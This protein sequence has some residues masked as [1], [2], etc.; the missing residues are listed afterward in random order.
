MLN[1]FIKVLRVVVIMAVV[2]FLDYLTLKVNIGCGFIGFG[3]TTRFEAFYC[4]VGMPVTLL[5]AIIGTI[6]S[7]IYIFSHKRTHVTILVCV[8]LPIIAIRLFLSWGDVD[9]FIR[10]EIPYYFS[11]YASFI[12]DPRTYKISKADCENYDPIKSTKEFDI[13]YCFNRFHIVINSNNY[14]FCDKYQDFSSEAVTNCAFRTAISINDINFCDNSFSNK[15]YFFS[16]TLKEDFIKACTKAFNDKNLL[17][18]Y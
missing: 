2:V 6:Y 17:F 11:G 18:P 5:L 12:F 3:T 15:K 7:L 4:S 1:N 8:F 9:N 14:D 10:R 16:Y 13:P